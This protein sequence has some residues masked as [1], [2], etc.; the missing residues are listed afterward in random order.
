MLVEC[1]V[2]AGAVKGGATSRTLHKRG[3]GLR[4]PRDFM[5]D[6]N[7]LGCG[8]LGL[9]RRMRRPAGSDELRAWNGGSATRPLAFSGR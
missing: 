3:E 1:G 9:L 7:E 8:L 4:H 2:N 5:R 6:L